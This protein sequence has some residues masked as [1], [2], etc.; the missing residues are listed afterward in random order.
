MKELIFYPPCKQ[1]N[2]LSQFHGFWQKTQVSWVRDKGCNIHGTTSSKSLRLLVSTPQ[3]QIPK[4]SEERAKW[5]LHMGGVVSQ[6]GLGHLNP[7]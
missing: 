4:R 5:H 6:G 7:L 1:K 2:S 3:A